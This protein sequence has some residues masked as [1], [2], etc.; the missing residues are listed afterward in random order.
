MALSV[1]P[2]TMSKSMFDCAK[3]SLDRTEPVSALIAMFSFSG[4][5]APYSIKS[6]RLLLKRP[7]EQ[8]PRFIIIIRIEKVTKMR[9]IV[10]LIRN[11]CFSTFL[12]SE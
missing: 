6:I 3:A 10:L 12:S 9:E 11:T 7:Y 4:Y 8:M 1:R 2:L 5:F